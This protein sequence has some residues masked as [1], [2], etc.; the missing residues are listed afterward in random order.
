MMFGESSNSFD[1]ADFLPTEE[2][3][4]KFLAD[5]MAFSDPHF[6]DRAHNIVFKSRYLSLVPKA[7]S[8]AIYSIQIDQHHQSICKKV[9]R[10]KIEHNHLMAQHAAILARVKARAT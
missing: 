1:P 10:L 2:M 8:A 3:R 4:M 9:D 6:L 7:L 5:A